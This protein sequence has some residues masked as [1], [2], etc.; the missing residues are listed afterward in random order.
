[1]M[2]E[3]TTLNEPTSVS[4]RTNSHSKLRKFGIPPSRRQTGLLIGLL[5]VVAV[6]LWRRRINPGRTPAP[7]E[8]P[9]NETVENCQ[10]E[11]C[12]SETIYVPQGPDDELEKDAA[13]LD[14]LRGRGK[15]G[16]S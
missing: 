1:M 14:S 10:S 13:V 11:E 9:E 6:I 7:E 4:E 5:V 3:S 8:A 12:E 15:L 2:N 16:A